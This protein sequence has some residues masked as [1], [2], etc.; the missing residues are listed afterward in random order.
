MEVQSTTQIKVQ[1][2]IMSYGAETL[3]SW[4]DHFDRI[5]TSKDYPVYRNLEKQ[6]CKAC[7]IT[8]ADMK[9]TSNTE[10][11]NAKRIITF[12]SF[13]QIK[14]SVSSISKLLNVSDRTVNYYIKEAECWINAPKTN[15]V[16]VE[17]YNRVIE[18]FKIS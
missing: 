11:T 3:I 10:S 17:A 6:A 14:L 16:F 18:N 9:L 8:L 1:K 2:F 12:I 13:H 15:K 5:I 7:D 4:L